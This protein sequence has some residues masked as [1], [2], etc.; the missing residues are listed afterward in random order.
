M[1][2]LEA[3]LARLEQ[4]LAVSS[5]SEIEQQPVVDQIAHLH[6]SLAALVAQYPILRRVIDLDSPATSSSADQQ[7]SPSDLSTKASIALAHASDITSLSSS[8]ATLVSV[9]SVLDHPHSPSLITATTP[10]LT[11]LNARISCLK[12]QVATQLSRS[13]ALFDRILSTSVVGTNLA[14]A[15]IDD[16]LVAID[17]KL[18]RSAAAANAFRLTQ[19]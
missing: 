2:A 19:Q 6:T 5:S 4:L 16:R 12:V 11:Q 14:W 17:A 1:D 13:I 3:R 18:S 8:L 7:Q 10:H 15:E 9:S